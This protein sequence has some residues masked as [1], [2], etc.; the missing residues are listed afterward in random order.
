MRA[1]RVVALVV[2]CL[3]VIPSIALLFGGGALGLGY[4]FGRG[5]D[6]YFDTTLDRLGTETVAITADDIT[7]AAEP[8][9]PDWVLDL[10]DT[11][12]RIRATGA[13]TSEEVF[14]GIAR[15]GD[16][17]DYL[18]GVAHD[19]VVDLTDDLEPVFR[20]RADETA[21]AADVVALAPP[22]DQTFWVATAVGPG[23]QELEWE[24]AAGRW[25]VV[26][27]NADA[28][29]GVAVAVNVGVT[30]D[31]VLPLAFTM[32]GVGVL[33]TALAV[34]L[35]VIGARDAGRPDEPEPTTGETASPAHGPPAANWDP[36]VDP[37]PVSLT[38]RLDP[39]LSRW[40]WLVKWILAIPHA[41]VLAFLW[42]AF[43]VL[44]AVAAVAI[45]FTGRYPRGIFDFNVGVLRWTWRV[46]YYASTGGIGTDQYPPFGLGPE[47]DDPASLDI[48]YPERLSRGL[49]F[50]K[51]FL[52]IPHLLLIGLMAGTSIRWFGS[53]GVG[54]DVISGGGVLGLLVVVAGVVL[55]FRGRY[56]TALFDL[57][58]G[59]NRWIYRTIAYVA[60]MTDTYPPFRL[61]QGADEPRAAPDPP[62]APAGGAPFASPPVFDEPAAVS[63]RKER[64]EVST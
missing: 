11:D 40:Q 6:G 37:H 31:F 54:F 17:D 39:E 62:P 56:P 2:G 12:V 19:E 41:I 22:A 25:A 23:T 58:V 53:D 48:A 61:D 21:D 1:S 16:V 44:T 20:V 57:I 30:A 29:P 63:A 18:E 3:L 10:L 7:F 51:W 47:P 59:F 50:V 4:A 28:T 8:G 27:M 45:V 64:E 43:V 24:A 14:V 46:S 32:L 13:G 60:L 36:P 52:A 34:T 33:L 38:A 35:I 49:V 42:M 9:S 26:V 5:D 55:L 15:Q